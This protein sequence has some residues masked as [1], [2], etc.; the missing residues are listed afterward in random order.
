MGILGVTESQVSSQSIT[1]FSSLDFL[2][3]CELR[4]TGNSSHHPAPF[5]PNCAA[6]ALF[7]ALRV[8]CLRQRGSE[9]ISDHQ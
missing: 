4:L 5:S 3:V 7:L 9:L 6:Q 1:A 8:Q 2:P